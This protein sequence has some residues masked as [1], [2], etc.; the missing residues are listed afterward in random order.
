MDP[1]DDVI[2]EEEEV[3]NENDNIII[4][5][6]ILNRVEKFIFPLYTRFVKR[7]PF[8]NYV[9]FIFKIIEDLQWLI[10]SLRENWFN[11]LNYFFY[12]V[13]KNLPSKPRL[14]QI[15]NLLYMMYIFSSNNIFNNNIKEIMGSSVEYI[16]LAVISFINLILHTIFGYIFAKYFVNLFILNKNIIISRGSTSIMEKQFF[17]KLLMLL[18]IDL[19]KYI[20]TKTES[21]II[22]IVLLYYILYSYLDYFPYFKPQMNYFSICFIACAL[23]QVIISLIFISVGFNNKIAWIICLSSSLIILPIAWFYS[24]YKFNKL[25]NTLY[26]N[27]RERKILQKK[28]INPDYI[29]KLDNSELIEAME[30]IIIKSMPKIKK[31]MF[32]KEHHCEIACRYI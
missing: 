30:D 9:L 26:N 13:L 21:M 7:L 17:I 31:N 12:D 27:I 25:I 3:Q 29:N 24:K 20:L 11:D 19:F 22:A 28:K 10:F 6:P 2:L 23:Y 32:K 1:N 16:I 4:Y 14:L 8:N 18:D 15:L 5:P